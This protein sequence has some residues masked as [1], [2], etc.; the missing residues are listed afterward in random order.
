MLIQFIR[1]LLSPGLTIKLASA[2]SGLFVLDEISQDPIDIV[3]CHDPHHPLL[4]ASSNAARIRPNQDPSTKPITQVRN[5][6]IVM[7]C[8]P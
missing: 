4:F 8:P 1:E 7:Y 3:T 2:L 5:I 6:S